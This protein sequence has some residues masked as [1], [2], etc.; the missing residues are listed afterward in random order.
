[1]MKEGTPEHKEIPRNTVAFSSWNLQ[2][3]LDGWSENCNTDVFLHDC[4]IRI[5]ED[6]GILKISKTS[7]FAQSAKIQTPVD[8]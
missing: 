6:K 7:T 3:M 8:C 4:F 5:G 1:M 2:I